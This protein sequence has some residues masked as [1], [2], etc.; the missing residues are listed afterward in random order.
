VVRLEEPMRGVAP[1]QS[2]VLYQGTRV[3]GQATVDR[4]HSLARPDVPG[5]AGRPDPAR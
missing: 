2:V 1:G 4:A 5:G 3:L